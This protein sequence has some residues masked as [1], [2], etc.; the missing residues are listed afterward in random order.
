MKGV[1]APGEGLARETHF[2]VEIWSRK[3]EGMGR[4]QRH[5]S[6]YKVLDDEIQKGVHALQI[7]TKGADGQA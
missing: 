7:V 2:H 4:L 1:E 6:V 5:R 3:F